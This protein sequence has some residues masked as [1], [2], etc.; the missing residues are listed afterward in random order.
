[1]QVGEVADEEGAQPGEE[2][3]LA[4][5]EE[6]HVAAETEGEAGEVGSAPG[7]LEQTRGH[8]S[9]AEGDHRAGLGDHLEAPVGGGDRHPV[10]RRGPGGEGPQS[11]APDSHGA[12]SSQPRR[13][14]DQVV[15]IVRCHSLRA[16]PVMSVITCLTWVYSSKE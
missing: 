5:T 10:G 4:V 8:R 1:M 7:T 2:E 16:A 9:R 6:Q 11:R 3:L 13:P 12:D 14:L 15:K